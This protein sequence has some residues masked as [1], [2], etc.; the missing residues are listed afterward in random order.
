[1]CFH[2]LTYYPRKPNFKFCLSIPYTDDL[3]MLLIKLNESQSAQVPDLGSNL[4][5]FGNAV[6]ETYKSIKT[7]DFVRNIFKEFYNSTRMHGV[8]PPKIFGPKDQVKPKNTYIEPDL[9]NSPD[10]IESG[11]FQFIRAILSLVLD[12]IIRVFKNIFKFN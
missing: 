10:K 6:A 9:C 11:I 8:C 12:S 5:T 7:N 1:M 2:F 3:A 4:Q